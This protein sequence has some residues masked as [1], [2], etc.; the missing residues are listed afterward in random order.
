MKNNLNIEREKIILKGLATKSDI[1]I[2]L[3]CGPEKAKDIFKA[4]EKEVESEGK[5]NFPGRIHVK[6]LIPYTG[7]TEKQIL[8]YADRERKMILREQDQIK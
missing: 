5:L 3:K 8:D 6:R 7:L 1:M 4:V 2:F